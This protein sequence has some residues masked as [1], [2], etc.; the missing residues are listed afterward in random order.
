MW[1]ILRN[2]AYEGKA[3]FG[4]TELRPRQRITR[5]S[6]SGIGRQAVTAPTVNG[7]VKTGSKFLSRAGPRRHLR[8]RARTVAEEQTSFATAFDRTNSASGH[9]C[10]PTYDAGLYAELSSALADAGKLDEAAAPLLEAAKLNPSVGAQGYYNLG[11]SLTNRGKI[12]GGSR[13]LQQS[14]CTRCQLCESVLPAR[15]RILRFGEHDAAGGLRFGE[16][17]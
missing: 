3:C 1:G 4:K 14:D 10:L 2:P 11:V 16:I 15:N 7:L 5:S 6:V 12:E 8:S 13:C 17:S 9:A